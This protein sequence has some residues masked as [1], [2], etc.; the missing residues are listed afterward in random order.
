MSEYK[1]ITATTLGQLA[2]GVNAVL[3]RWKDDDWKLVGHAV[4]MMQTRNIGSY[5]DDRSAV[6]TN[7]MEVFY[8]QTMVRWGD[9][10]TLTRQA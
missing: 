5:Q 4:Q 6:N 10:K 9:Q 3:D 2:V 1:V 7:Q 8:T